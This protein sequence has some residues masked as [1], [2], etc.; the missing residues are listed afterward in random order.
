MGLP[1]YV[2]FKSVLYHTF[3][4]AIMDDVKEYEDGE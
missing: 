4:Q 2:L 3:W 1:A